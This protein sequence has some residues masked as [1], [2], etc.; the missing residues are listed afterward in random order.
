MD[1]RS[2][3]LSKY[4]ANAFLA[5]RISFINEIARLCESV[6]ADVEHVSRRRVGFTNRPPVFFQASV[7]AALL[8][9]RR[10]GT[11]EHSE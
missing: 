11:H 7:T 5:T 9:Q 1:N 2:A 6:G 8:P 4:A 10:Q 3:E